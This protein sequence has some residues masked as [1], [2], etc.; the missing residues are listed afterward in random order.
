MNSESGADSGLLRIMVLGTALACGAMAGSLQALRARAAG[1]YFEISWRTA[2]VFVIG[3][4]L[5][6]WIW[7]IMLDESDSPRQRLAR[8][9][10][11]SFLFA[12]AAAAFLYPLRF[13]PRSKLPDIAI[14]LSLAIFVLSIVGILVWKTRRF[15]EEDEREHE[16]K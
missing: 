14:G 5:I 11:K 9:V 7:R 3:T 15:L 13:V 8:R 1:F 16:I 12:S 6:L 4:V 10:A 2:V